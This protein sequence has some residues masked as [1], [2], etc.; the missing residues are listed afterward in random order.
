MSREPSDI[1]KSLYLEIIDELFAKICNN[2]INYSLKNQVNGTS[3]PVAIW[4]KYDEYNCKVLRYMTSGKLDRHKQASCLCGAIIEVK[5]LTGY[6]G[7]VVLK[8]ANEI[9]ALHVG[10]NVIKMY[11]MYDFIG[12]LDI[13]PDEKNEAKEYIKEHFNMQFPGNIC[14]NQ[15]YEDNFVNAL[16]WCHHECPYKKECIQYD[17]W[18]YSKLFFHLELYNQEFLRKSYEEYKK[19]KK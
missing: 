1:Y 2:S 17:V 13:S 10:L 19:S 3:V 9:L 16:Y 15:G 4:E 7:A 14:D 6:K 5:P 8:R 12:Q 18:A 11:M